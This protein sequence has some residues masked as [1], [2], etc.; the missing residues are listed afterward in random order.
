MNIK[1]ALI[2]LAMGK[3]IYGKTYGNY[4]SY[5]LSETEGVFMLVRKDNDG[6]CNVEESLVYLNS[7]IKYFLELPSEEK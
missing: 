6:E 2:A 7:N 1:E 5:Q 3:K 4:F